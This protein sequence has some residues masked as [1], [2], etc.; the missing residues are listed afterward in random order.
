M[1]AAP[2]RRHRPTS[3]WV[4]RVLLYL[5]LVAV[6]VLF[7][8]PFVLLLSTAMKPETQS[9]YGFPPS[10][11]PLPPVIDWFV[12]AWTLIPFAR[13]LLNSVLYV[14][15][16]I[17]LY[18]LVSA[19][20]AWPLARM[21][22]RGRSVFFILFLSLMFMPA[23]IMLVPRFLVMSELDL[24]DSYTA[25]ILVALLSSLGVF[26]LRQTFA[27]MPTEI[28]EAARIDGANEWGIFWRIALPV[29][30]PT[31]AVLAILGFISVWNSFIWPLVVLTSQDKFPIAL[32]IA[33]LTGVTGTDMRGLAAGTVMSLVPV[34]AVFI[35]LQ[36][37]ILSSMGGAVKG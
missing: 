28:I 10:V 9:I 4:R 22:F 30:K 35:V 5:A 33:Y 13:M 11:I 14:V 34:I 18:L 15:I 31:L 12:D 37:R 29:T 32:G 8:G 7:V 25:V 20:T 36:R 19:M 26:L 16:T 24:T 6:A 3:F 1:S 23:E 17:P 21:R 2:V 27:E